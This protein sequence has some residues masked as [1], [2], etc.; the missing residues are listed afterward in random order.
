MSQAV[1]SNAAVTLQ[2]VRDQRH[3]SEARILSA[4]DRFKNAI[5]PERRP[6]VPVHPQFTP[7]P[8]PQQSR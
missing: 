7:P 4:L 3:E 2:R 5:P 8:Q 1:I 6:G